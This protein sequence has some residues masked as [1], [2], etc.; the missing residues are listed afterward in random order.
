[1][2]PAEELSQNGL[3]GLTKLIVLVYARVG[4]LGVQL[5]APDLDVMEGE[6]TGPVRCAGNFQHPDPTPFNI[7]VSISERTETR[8]PFYCIL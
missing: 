8:L 5:C 7:T 2:F 1:M 4:G 6:S 3:T